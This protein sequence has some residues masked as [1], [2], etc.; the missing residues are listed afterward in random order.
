MVEYLKDLFHNYEDQITD[1]P[2]LHK[3]QVCKVD[4]LYF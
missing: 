3:Y 1:P 4:F 2:F